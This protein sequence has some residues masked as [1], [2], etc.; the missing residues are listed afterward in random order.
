MGSLLLPDSEIIHRTLEIKFRSVGGGLQGYQ[1]VAGDY[2][3]PAGDTGK[4]PQFPEW[5]F[6][7]RQVLFRVLGY[8]VCMEMAR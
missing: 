8:R 6:R 2:D 1:H 5:H 4:L 7:L 3:N